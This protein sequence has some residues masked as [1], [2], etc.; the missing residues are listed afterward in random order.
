M[1]T[2]AIIF[3]ITRGITNMPQGLLVLSIGGDIAIAWALAVAC[4]GWPKD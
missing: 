1:L 3:G 2:W 4:R